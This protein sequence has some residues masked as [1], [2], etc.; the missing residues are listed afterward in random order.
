MEDIPEQ[1]DANGDILPED[2]SRMSSLAEDQET[3]DYAEERSS[4]CLNL[5]TNAWWCIREC[6]RNTDANIILFVLGIASGYACPFL[7]YM[8]FTG[9]LCLVMERCSVYSKTRV[10]ILSCVY[11]AVVFETCFFAEQSYRNLGACEIGRLFHKSIA[12]AEVDA[13]SAGLSAIALNLVCFNHVVNFAI[14]AA[15]QLYCSVS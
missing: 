1:L 3:L 5:L 4:C 13:L 10:H 6:V 8:C 12:N 11:L 15:H 2:G 9:G 7:S 14:V